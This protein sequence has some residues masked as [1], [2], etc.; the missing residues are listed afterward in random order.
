MA[1]NQPLK[2]IKTA[3]QV[4][5]QLGISFPETPDPSDI[6]I[7][8]DTITSLFAEEP[9]RDLIHLPQ[10]TE[11]SKLAAMQILS[12]IM[13]AAY[14]A[15]P[16]FMP[17]LA[18]KQVNLS[19]QY[20]NAFV[21]PFAYAIF[22]MT[23]C[24]RVGNIESAYQFGQLALGMLSRSNSHSLKARTLNIINNFIIHWKEHNRKLLKPLLEAYQGE[25]ETGD[26]EFAAY[27]AY[28]YCFQSFVI[29]KELVNVEREMRTYSEAIRQIKHEIAFNWIQIFQQTVSNLM[30]RSL[31]PTRLVG[32]FYN[33]ESKL[34]QLQAANDGNS[35]FKVYF[36]KL[37]L[38]YLFSKYAQA[39]KSSDLAESHLSYVTALPLTPLYNFYDSLARLAAYPESNVQVQLEIL[40]KVAIGQEKMKHW[41][42]YA[43]MN[44]LHKYHLVEAEKARVLGQ[45]LEAEK[46]YEQAIQGARENG[47]IQEEALAYELAAKHYLARGL[48]KFAQLYMKE[49]HYCYERWGAIAKVKDLETRYPQLFPQSSNI[50]STSVRTA[51]G[52]A[53]NTS[54][55]TTSNT[56]LDLAT[57]MKA[58]QAISSEIELEQC[59]VL[60]C[61]F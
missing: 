58:A 6:R 30:E 17:L 7:E 55:T 43:P 35:I 56:A 15:V 10:M 25:L 14:I 49:A 29:G 12:R 47:Y 27:S 21:S 11:P 5:Q 48:E 40:K 24:G 9:I 1:Q 44:C 38:Y 31:N 32:E 18:A 51:T 33:E 42:N 39:V 41:A 20:G 50:V 2:A 19:I 28:N 57:V 59:S 54:H 23:L 3:L 46:F 60:S 45:L 36:N 22:G 37:F 26:F 52:T 4:L 53:S 61:R 34:P 8:L 16:D 13:I